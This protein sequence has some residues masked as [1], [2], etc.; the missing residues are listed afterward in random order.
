MYGRCVECCAECPPRTLRTPR[1]QC[2]ALA[3][4]DGIDDERAQLRL[5]LLATDQAPRHRREVQL[6]PRLCKLARV[7]ARTLGGRL[8]RGR[9]LGRRGCRDDGTSATPPT[10]AAS[11]WHRL[12][13]IRCDCGWLRGYALHAARAQAA[14]AAVECRER[15][16]ALSLRA[17]PC[18]RTSKRSRRRYVTCCLVRRGVAESKCRRRRRMQ[19]VEPSSRPQT[20]HVF[21]QRRAQMHHCHVSVL[22]T[23]VS[24]P[25]LL[26]L[27]RPTISSMRSHP[28]RSSTATG[29]RRSDPSHLIHC[30]SVDL[31]IEFLKA[32]K[33]SRDQLD[34]AFQLLKTNM[35]A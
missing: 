30:R 22:A 33:M 19:S 35:Q 13:D 20:R 34:W 9:G 16:E 10:T 7:L 24:E 18:S 1:T 21:L 3:A 5:L 14:K 27:T 23:Q 17:A 4:S 12:C 15:S 31:T 25:C 2:G 29:A 28:S 6:S 32:E 11:P 26:T 8:E